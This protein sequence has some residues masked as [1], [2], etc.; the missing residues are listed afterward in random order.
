MDNLTHSLTGL[1]LSR[2]GLHRGEKGTAVMMVLAA[3]IPDADT[4]SFF[5][6]PLTYLEVH[7]GW[8]HSFAIS[9]IM[10]LLAV[11]IVRAFTR[12]RP[13]FFEWFMCWIAVLSHIL[14]DWTNVYGVR[15]LAPFS[16]EWLHLDLTYIV[17]PIIWLIFGLA[18][19]APALSGLVGSEIASKKRAGP[20]RAWAWVALLGLLAYQGLRWDSHRKVISR[21]DSILYEGEPASRLFA[22]PPGPFGYQRWRGLAEGDLF[23]AEVPV[24]LSEPFDPGEVRVI[25]KIAETAAM[26][27]AKKTRTFRVFG[28]FNQ[29]PFWQVAPL[30]NGTRVELLDLRFGTPASPGFMASALVRS[31]G[32]VVDPQFQFGVPVTRP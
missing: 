22:F 8:T 17:D 24:D 27:E 15:L 9:P 20:K 29:V 2:I 23:Y 6:D 10:A 30:E 14:L 3:N 21:L 1:M 31:D 5:T 19:A 25:Y 28:E 4:Y 11:G 7:R 18:V 13:T 32:Q 16:M 12:T 26:R